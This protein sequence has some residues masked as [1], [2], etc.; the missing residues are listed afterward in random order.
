M[1]GRSGDDAH[2]DDEDVAFSPDG[3]LGLVREALRDLEERFDSVSTAMLN[4]PPVAVVLVGGDLDAVH[5]LLRRAG[6]AGPPSSAELYRW[7]QGAV[8]LRWPLGVLGG[9]PVRLRWLVKNARAVAEG[10]EAA[11]W[12]SGR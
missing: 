9:V 11:E 6:I 10:L 4:E 7:Q 1:A 5:S 12:P 3:P 2:E 8:T